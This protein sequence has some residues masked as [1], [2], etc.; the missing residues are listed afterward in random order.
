MAEDPSREP[1]KPVSAVDVPKRCGARAGSIIE[2]ARAAARDETRFTASSLRFS[3]WPARRPTIRRVFERSLPST[4]PT[5]QSPKA[6]NRPH[7]WAERREPVTQCC[8]SRHRLVLKGCDVRKPSPP[9]AM[10]AG[11][12]YGLAS[13]GSLDTAP[14]SARP[15]GALGSATPTV[16]GSRHP[17]ESGIDASE[18]QFSNACM[19]LVHPITSHSLATPSY[20]PA[21]RMPASSRLP[22]VYFVQESPWRRLLRALRLG[23]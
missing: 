20:Q 8:R 14:H 5:M 18:Q 11:F 22:S 15:A 6:R 4:S 3:H 7:D 16:V 10:V 13:V 23:R 1:G 12:S 19:R 21:R 2:P 9:P 17:P